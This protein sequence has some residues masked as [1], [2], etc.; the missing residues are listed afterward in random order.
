MEKETFNRKELY[1]LVWSYPM[2]T[3]SKKYN[4][5]DNGLRKMCYRMNIPLPPQGH[6]QK[7]QYGKKVEVIR[8]PSN[9]NGVNEVCLLPKAMDGNQTSQSPQTI[10]IKE[11]KA[12]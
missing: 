10:L 6:W 12:D 4:I 8:L 7:V 11:I 2:L 1:D 9:Y 3:L 5:S